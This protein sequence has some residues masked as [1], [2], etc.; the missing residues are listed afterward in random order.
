MDTAA[1]TSA[2]TSVGGLTTKNMAELSTDD[3]LNLLI[4]ELTN[5]DPFEPVKNQ[6]LL[7]QISSIREM[8]M[9][10]QLNETLQSL[11]L[12]G[13]L[14]AA[15]G[16]IGKAVAGMTG[17]LEMVSGIVAGV[18]VTNGD[19]MLELA[20]GSEVNID[21]VTHVVAAETGQ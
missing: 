4:T 21:D 16:L 11:V 3:F 15:A 18:R 9:S 19:V 17:S 7:N 6:D 20:N 8:E 12:Q 14:A 10:T 5:Q 1:L 13:N 2:T